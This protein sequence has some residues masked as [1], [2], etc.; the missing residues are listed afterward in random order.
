VKKR[1]PNPI[2]AAIQRSF[3]NG[4]VFLFDPDRDRFDDRVEELIANLTGEATIREIGLL[5][6]KA[7]VLGDREIEKTLKDALK[8]CDHIFRRDR[9][10]VL[11][12]K[13]I[14]NLVKPAKA[15]CRASGTPD[16]VAIKKVIEE[17]C[18]CGKK[19]TQSQ[20]NRLRNALDMDSLPT[21][22]PKKSGKK[23]R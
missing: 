10:R 19:L 12:K 13:V 3:P 2:I 21:G 8:E 16:I 22:R 5:L 4:G 23:Q 17:R 18:N 7:L 1:K 11:L 14:K 6:V 20:W 9:E 15:S